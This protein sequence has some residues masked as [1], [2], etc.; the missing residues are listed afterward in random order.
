LAEVTRG[1]FS[2]TLEQ[3]FSWARA[4][5]LW[6]FAIDNTCCANEVA[7]TFGC[8]YDFERFGCL[9]Q[10]DP[11]HADVLLVS[12]MIS[13]KAEPE[14]RAIYESMPYPRYVIAIGSCSCRGGAFGEEFSYVGAVSIEQII[15][16]DVFVPGCPPRPEAI[17]NGLIT[18][19]EKIRG[20]QRAQT[21]H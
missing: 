20:N 18:L 5:S 6:T 3:L 7:Q 12:G 4:G 16:V 1:F 15:P 10:T 2:S 19:Q 17:M 21:S 11:R 9:K 8:R 14:L 13:K